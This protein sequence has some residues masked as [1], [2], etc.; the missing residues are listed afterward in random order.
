MALLGE[1][2]GY[3]RPLTSTI[4]DVPF[5]DYFDDDD[6][7]DGGERA[8]EERQSQDKL[9]RQRLARIERMKAFQAR[10]EI[11]EEK[12]GSRVLYQLI[13]FACLRMRITVL[14]Y[15]QYFEPIL[16]G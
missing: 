8:K 1:S 14:A 5:Q 16:I 12:V 6:D 11:Q 2:R 15:C 4:L 7:G 10:T 3:F 13:P 9:E